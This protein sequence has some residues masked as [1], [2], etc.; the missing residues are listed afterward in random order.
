MVVYPEGIWYGHVGKEKIG[1]IVQEHLVEGNPV[2]AL[3]VTPL[4]PH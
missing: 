2:S 1:Q 3:V 4:V